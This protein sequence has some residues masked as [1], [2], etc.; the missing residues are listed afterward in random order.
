[1]V[2]LAGK[3]AEGVIGTYPSVPQNTKQYQAF[4]EAYK[5]KY[6]DDKIPIFGDYN[7]DMVYVTAKAIEKG[8]Y[9]ADGIRKALPAAAKGFKGVTGDKTFDNER[10][11]KFAE[12]G[13]WIVKDGKIEDYKK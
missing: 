12:Y 13:I 4:K 10:S 8:G 1:M 5:K 3:A 9:T 6:G 2:E 7:Y 11:P